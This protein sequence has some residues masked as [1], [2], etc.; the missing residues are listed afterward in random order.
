MVI[1]GYDESFSAATAAAGGTVGIIIP[2]SIIFIVYGFF[3]NLPISD[4][5]VAGIIPGSLMVLAM[6][7]ACFIICWKNGWGY[8][9]PLSPLR[10]LKTGLGAWLGFFAIGLVLWGIYNRK[11][12]LTEATGVTVGFCI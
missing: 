9:I 10:V 3:L 7:L 4:L 11:S 12:S 5:F 2:P 1:G 8:L 6:M